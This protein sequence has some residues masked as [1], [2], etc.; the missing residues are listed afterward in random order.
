MAVLGPFGENEIKTH[1]ASLLETIK[2]SPINIWCF[3][4]DMGAGKT[5]TISTLLNLA[6]VDDHVSS[7]TFSIVNEYLSP[8]LGD[9]YHFDFYRIE[10]EE[11]AIEI[12][13]LEYFDS[14][15]LCLIEW[16][17]QIPGL[18]PEEIGIVTITV[19]ENNQR[20]LNITNH[21]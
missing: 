17:S 16:S 10:D 5:T 18:L 6:G 7:P 9:V 3:N 1:I 8:T 19:N 4:G 20:I 15:N 2:Q 21:E 13:T 14:G 11:E 12:G